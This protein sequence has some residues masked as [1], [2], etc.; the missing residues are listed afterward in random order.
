MIRALN[1]RIS[2]YGAIAAM[3]PKTFLAYSAW[4]WVELFAQALMMLILSS[5]WRA[6]YTN[7]TTLGGLNVQQTINYILLAQVFAPLVEAR[8]IW[9]IGWLLREGSMAIEL[10]RPL[11]FQLRSFVESLTEMV[12][13]LILKAPLILVA[14]LLFGLQ[15]P[16]DPRVWG[17]F[18]LSIV[19]TRFRLRKLSL[20]YMNLSSIHSPSTIAP[21]AS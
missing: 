15:L 11:D 8:M 6:V 7:S 1:R 14:W 12:T 16:N 21:L 3:L 18:I 17:A 2:I 13:D 9:R 5:F 19:W 20:T 4:V 10:L